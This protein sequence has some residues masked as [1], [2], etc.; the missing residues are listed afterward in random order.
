M[1]RIIKQAWGV[2]RRFYLVHVHPRYVREQREKRRGEC[3]R[4]GDCC[5]L[6]MRCPFLEDEN[7]C[8][9]YEK[10]SEQCRMFP[11]DDRDLKDCPTCSFRFVEEGEEEGLQAEGKDVGVGDAG[12]S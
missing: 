5:L 10:R 6:V 8:S 9:I 7:Q 2:V 12:V 11:I 1:W 3:S 4:C